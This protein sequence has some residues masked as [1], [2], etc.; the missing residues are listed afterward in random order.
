MIATRLGFTAASCSVCSEHSV[1]CIA[2]RASQMPEMRMI[3]I[4][5]RTRSCFTSYAL[6]TTGQYT[7]CVQTILDI[8]CT[9]VVSCYTCT[10]QHLSQLGKRL[11]TLETFISR[12][13]LSVLSRRCVRFGV[14]GTHLLITNYRNQLT[15]LPRS[16]KMSLISWHSPLELYS[17]SQSGIE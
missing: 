5:I 1:S 11:T 4:E 12:H 2:E 3:A 15:S 8:C 6:K 17:G 7:L 9:P 14:T 13:C 10:S 16:V